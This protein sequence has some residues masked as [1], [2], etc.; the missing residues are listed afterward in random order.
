MSSSRSQLTAAGSFGKRTWVEDLYGP[1]CLDTSIR[2]DVEYE[3]KQVTDC[4]RDRSRVGTQWPLDERREDTLPRHPVMATP[5][6]AV[7]VTSAGRGTPPTSVLDA[8]AA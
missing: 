3:A 7:V 4:R 1:I 2:L 5:W 8:A 6:R